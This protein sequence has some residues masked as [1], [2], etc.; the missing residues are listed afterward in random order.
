M[1][2]HKI[3]RS[4]SPQ[5]RKIKSKRSPSKENQE[6]IELVRS[7]QTL[8]QKAVPSYTQ[9][10]NDIID[11]NCRNKRRIERA[12]DGMLDFC[13]YKNMLELFRKLCRYYYAIDR[14]ATA[15]YV[16]AYRDMWDSEAK[17][18]NSRPLK[19]SICPTN[20]SGKDSNLM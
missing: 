16:L 19:R 20:P 14:Y 15:E 12:L 1:T 13:F 6:I 7:L 2:L 17:V 8:A 18:A 5:K 4:K 3:K 10:M 11:S 9:E